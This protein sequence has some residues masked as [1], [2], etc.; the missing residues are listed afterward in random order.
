MHNASRL[1]HH[2]CPIELPVD[3]GGGWRGKCCEGSLFRAHEGAATWP[4][5]Q[6]CRA[7]PTPRCYPG[8]EPESRLQRRGLGRGNRAGLV[9]CQ[10]RDHARVISLYTCGPASLASKSVFKWGNG[11]SE[12]QSTWPRP[13]G[14]VILR[15]TEKPRTYRSIITAMVVEITSVCVGKQGRMYFCARGGPANGKNVG[16]GLQQPQ[17]HNLAL[18]GPGQVVSPLCA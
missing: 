1:P 4:P 13:H 5:T 11:G 14:V 17:A 6:I 8:P 10:R 12:H 15:R 2:K 9:L 3:P 16:F 7:A 18:C